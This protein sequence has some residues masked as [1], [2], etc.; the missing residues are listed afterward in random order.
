[1]KKFYISL[2]VIMLLCMPAGFGVQT[3][4]ALT[5]GISHISL[6]KKY[7]DVSKN[8]L[9]INKMKQQTKALSNDDK[10]VI[11]KY[12][13]GAVKGEDTY[14]LINCYLR[15]NLQDYISKKDIT[16]PLKCRLKFY[17]DAL[18]S[19]I[20]KAKLPQNMILYRGIDEKGMRALFGL[21]VKEYGNVVLNQPVSTENAEL[22]S[23]N[24]KGQ[25]FTEKGFMSTSYDKNCIKKTKFRFEV[26]APKNIQ[27]V[28]IEELGKP[29]EK[30]VIINCGYNWEVVAVSAE[31]DKSSKTTYYNIVIKLSL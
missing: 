31:F 13:F 19:T 9:V 21:G 6:V 27:A 11:K 10:N 22:L 28:L 23:K 15:G 30:E 8:F 5:K 3:Y 14:L 24:I 1:M 20:A 17:A 12:V 2:V 18:E 7:K 4:Q 25:K 16:T 29:Q 26:R